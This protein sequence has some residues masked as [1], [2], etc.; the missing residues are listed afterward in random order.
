MPGS[1][2]L[3][4]AMTMLW[5]FLAITTKDEIFRALAI[6]AASAAYGFS[7]YFWAIRLNK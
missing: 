4:S 5:A 2:A 3:A 7:A 1:I 6:L